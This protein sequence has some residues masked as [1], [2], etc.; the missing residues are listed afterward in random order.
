MYTCGKE[1]DKGVNMED[2]F[3]IVIITLFAIEMI[4]IAIGLF[5][6]FRLWRFRQCYDNN[7]ELSYC[8]RYKEY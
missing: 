8:E 6:V 2:K 3:K 5:E 4:I 7:F 1:Q